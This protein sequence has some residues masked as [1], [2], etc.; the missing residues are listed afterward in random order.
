MQ[1]TPDPVL[2]ALDV[3][4]TTGFAFGR[5]H[6]ARPTFGHHRC[7]PP[8]ASSGEAFLGFSRWLADLIGVAT[9]AVIFYEAPLDPRQIGGRTSMETMFRLIGMAAHV[10]TVA[11]GRGVYRVERANV[12]E[13]RSFFIGKALKRDDAK[14][15]TIAQARTLGCDVNDDNAADAIATWFYA[16]AVLN[17]RVAHHTAP[18]FL[19]ARK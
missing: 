16:S 11:Q 19:G 15:A 10:H 14:R 3:A 2:L 18:L 8:G 5:I 4:T 6:D 9:P 13:V 17:P 1:T 7:A 12:S